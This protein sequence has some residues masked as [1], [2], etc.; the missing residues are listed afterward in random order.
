MTRRLISAAVATVCAP[1]AT[2]LLASP[3]GAVPSC[4]DFAPYTRICQSPGHTAISTTPNPNLNN[5]LAGWGVAGIGTPV[6]GLGGG[7]FWLGF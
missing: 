6:F 1:L 2:V 7:G 4:E 3:V 5:P